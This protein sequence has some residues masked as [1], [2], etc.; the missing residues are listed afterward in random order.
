VIDNGLVYILWAAQTVIPI[1]ILHPEKMLKFLISG[2]AVSI[3]IIAGC[4]VALA[5]LLIAVF[6]RRKVAK[7][8][9]QWDDGALYGLLAAWL[10]LGI[11][12]V[13][14]LKNHLF[15]YYLTYSLPA[16]LALVLLVCR[17]FAHWVSMGHKTI[18]ILA[19]A[20][21]A[22]QFLL[23]AGYTNRVQAE[24]GAMFEGAGKI[25][26]VHGFLMSNY[27]SI[28]KDTT[29]VMEGANLLYALR[30]DRAIQLW[31]QDRSIRVFDSRFIERDGNSL[32]AVRP[33]VNTAFPG[34][35]LDAER[36][37]LDPK[38]VMWIKVSKHY[39]V[40]LCGANGENYGHG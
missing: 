30:N 29:L 6:R 13:Y 11:A 39:K 37:Q 5:G 19:I 25:E 22:S 20:F 34:S 32:F 8:K 2:N 12:P 18:T 31:Y 17:S 3:A 4:A 28:P 23:S 26:S 40:S 16:C 36:V 38:H 9:W 1:N 10:I 14:F 33:P 15:A 21:L 24:G 35:G 27:P 7:A